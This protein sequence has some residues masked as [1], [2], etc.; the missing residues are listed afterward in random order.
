MSFEGKEEQGYEISHF[1][2]GGEYF[3]LAVFATVVWI[4]TL[5]EKQHPE[6]CMIS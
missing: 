2:L 3:L 4:H 1:I 6:V 5:A